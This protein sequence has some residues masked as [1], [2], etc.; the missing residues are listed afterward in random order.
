MHIY[1]N[2]PYERGQ[3][4]AVHICLIFDIFSLKEQ[5]RGREREQTRLEGQISELNENVRRYVTEVK[6]IE[7]V[8]A[9]KE[10][11]RSEVLQQYKHL[12]LEIE[13]SESYGRKMAARWGNGMASGLYIG[14]Q[15]GD[16]GFVYIAYVL[17]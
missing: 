3:K 15:L 6:R 13:T 16:L 11:E 2:N 1:Q 8:A 17:R 14:H 9:I 5:L 10:K 4:P 12:S 7:E